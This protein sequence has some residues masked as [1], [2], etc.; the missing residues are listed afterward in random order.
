MRSVGLGGPTGGYNLWDNKA[1]AYL[2]S[3]C[4]QIGRLLGW[5]GNHTDPVTESRQLEAASSAGYLNVAQAS[6]V[7]HTVVQHT[8]SDRLRMTEPDQAGVGLGLELGRLLIREHE[9]PEQLV[10]QREL[11]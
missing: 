10:A 11:Q 4:P 7:L 1:K 3:K 5:A 8:I 9:A 6:G 2:L